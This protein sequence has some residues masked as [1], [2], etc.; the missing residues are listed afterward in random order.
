MS[1]M[2]LAFLENMGAEPSVVLEFTERSQFVSS[3]RIISH[4]SKSKKRMTCS[5]LSNV[6]I[7]SLGGL[8]QKRIVKGAALRGVISTPIISSDVFSISL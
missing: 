3:N 2:C 1:L 6:S 5:N 7:G 8:Y 4:P